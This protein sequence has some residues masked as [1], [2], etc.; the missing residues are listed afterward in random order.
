MKEQWKSELEKRKREAQNDPRATHELVTQVLTEPDENAAWEAVSTLQYRASRDVFDAACQLCGS[1]CPQERTLGANILGQLGIPDRSFPEESVTVLRK[2]LAVESDK[3]VLR[4]VCVALGH[5]HDPIAIPDLASLKT[6]H[7]VMVRYAVVFGL[8]SFKEELAV[9]TL[10]E[11]SRD[12]D[13][14]VRD[15]ATFG[16]GSQIE[17][18]TPPIREALVARLSDADEI[19]RSEALVGLARRK[20]ERVLDPLIRELERYP[21]EKIGDFAIEAAEEMADT[22]LLPILTR[23]KEASGGEKFDEAIKCC[24]E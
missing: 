22:R 6:H 17:A 3:D 7:N 18:D 12:Q 11:L 13:E 15:W 9:N 1:A 10:I 2:L 19:V 8:L 20:D 4:S 5:I 16:L 24:S 21:A 14:L 23:L